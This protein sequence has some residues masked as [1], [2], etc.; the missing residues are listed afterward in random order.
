MKKI[1]SLQEERKERKYLVDRRIRDTDGIFSQFQAVTFSILN[2]CMFLSSTAL[3]LL[4]LFGCYPSNFPTNLLS[5]PYLFSLPRSDGIPLSSIGLGLGLHVFLHLCGYIL[6]HCFFSEDINR[7]GKK[8]NP[9]RNHGLFAY[10]ATTLPLGVQMRWLLFGWLSSHY[11]KNTS[12]G[13]V[14]GRRVSNFHNRNLLST[15]ATYSTMPAMNET[16]LLAYLDT[17]QKFKK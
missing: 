9:I 16:L 10:E 14:M 15:F 1:L 4:M 5:A 6:C 11:P 13:P 12:M 17:L 3:D 2:Q 8:I 7:K